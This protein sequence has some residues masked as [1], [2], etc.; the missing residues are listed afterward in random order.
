VHAGEK[1][2]AFV[3]LESAMAA[4]VKIGVDNQEDKEEQHAESCG[5]R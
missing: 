1:L 4:L 5:D 3:E 2:T